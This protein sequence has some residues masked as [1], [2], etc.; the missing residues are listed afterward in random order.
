MLTFLWGVFAA[1]VGAFFGAYFQEKG[2]NRA[3][4]EDIEK[5][6][7][8]V[9]SV[10]AESAK[11]LAEI[12]HQNTVLIEQLRSR[13]QMRMAAID[14]RLQAHQEAFKFW[15][16]LY[17]H[18]HSDEI[19]AIVQECQV[20]WEDNCLYLDRT[21]RDAFANAY[22]AASQHKAYLNIPHTQNDASAAAVVQRMTDNWDKI[23]DAG[24][25][26]I[27]AA[28]LPGLTSVERE[29]LREAAQSA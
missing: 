23:K 26:I 17:Q 11:Q 15:R 6:T 25:I 24:D 21:A 9:E 20:W 2:K 1:G 13:N 3:T 5:L 22:W 10:K 28:D 18:A 16:R 27:K 7:R 19:G 4:S 12:Q 29:E 14:K 8:V